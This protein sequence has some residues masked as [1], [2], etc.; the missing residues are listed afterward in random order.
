MTLKI[1][2]PTINNELKLNTHLAKAIIIKNGKLNTSFLIKKIVILFPD[3]PA[4]DINHIIIQSHAITPVI[5]KR[6]R[7]KRALPD[8]PPRKRDNQREISSKMLKN[9]PISCL[10]RMSIRPWIGEL[11]NTKKI[12]KASICA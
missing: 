7:A 4:F 5:E 12:H 11:I 2:K 10:S 8:K 6:M 3:N 9:N 1:Y